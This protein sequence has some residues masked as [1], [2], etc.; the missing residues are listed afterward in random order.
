MQIS[1]ISIIST[2]T[3]CSGE[4]IS[5]FAL[6]VTEKI[7]MQLTKVGDRRSGACV[8]KDWR[9]VSS[10]AD[11]ML[12]ILRWP[13]GTDL[14]PGLPQIISPESSMPR[15]MKKNIVHFAYQ[16]C[17]LNPGKALH[18]TSFLVFL[19]SSITDYG[20]KTYKPHPTNALLIQFDRELEKTIPCLVS[21]PKWIVIPKQTFGITNVNGLKKELV[22]EE[23][24]KIE[25]AKAQGFRKLTGLELGYGVFFGHL[26]ELNKFEKPMGD[27]N[28][29]YINPWVLDPNHDIKNE[30][31]IT[32]INKV[33]IC[34]DIQKD[35]TIVESYIKFQLYPCGTPAPNAISKQ[36]YEANSQ[37][38]LTGI[39]LGK[40]FEA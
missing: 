5:S 21:K 4:L 39:M 18:E 23:L 33:V 3:K 16:P 9:L 25:K 13:F 32:K 36:K 24:D 1:P 27:K 8:C 7:F 28:A 6:E 31:D 35:G 30:N 38:F 29:E 22:R 26:G 19:G 12:R 15:L 17:P 10:Y 11:K 20:D 14:Q 37:N 2:P 40:E 34:E